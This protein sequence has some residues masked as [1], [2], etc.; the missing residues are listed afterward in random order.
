MSA[1]TVARSRAHRI[2]GDIVGYDER[3][4]F[5]VVFG[6]RARDTARVDSDVDIALGLRPGAEMSR[7]ER[8][9]LAT[10]LAEALGTDVDLVALEEAPTA[11]AYRI[12]RDGITV[13]DRDHRALSHCRANAILRYLDFRPVEKLCT[14]GALRAARNGR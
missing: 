13:L 11:L 7:A 1:H 14:E 3:I 8:E 9:A 6:S 5:A 10:R 12:F 2:I 4:A